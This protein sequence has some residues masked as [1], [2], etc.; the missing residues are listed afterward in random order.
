MGPF[1]GEILGRSCRDE[2][3]RPNVFDMTDNPALESLAD[4]DLEYRV[5]RTE[6]ARSAEES[7]GFQGIPLSALLRTLV[8]RRGEGDYLFVLVPGG[9]KFDW[10]KLRDLLGV[11]RMTM[12]DAE[13]AREVTGYERGAITPFGARM[14]L[15]VIIDRAAMDQPMVAIG[16]GAHGVNVHLSPRDLADHLGA[17]VA[18]ISVP[19]D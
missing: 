19:E 15:P 7:A 17:R 5:V 16:G 4:S 9:R 18:D 11:R 1:G 12:P 2:K 10:P 8:V 14:Q 13:E 6:R 3:V